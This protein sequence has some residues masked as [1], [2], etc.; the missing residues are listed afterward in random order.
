[1]DIVVANYNSNNVGVFLGYGDGSFANQTTYSTDEEPKSIAVADLNNDSILDIV[2]AN[3][4]SNNLGVFL[5]H[6]D[7]T[8]AKMIRVPLE[9]GSRPFMILVGDFNNDGKLDFAVANNG[10]DSLQILL[11]TC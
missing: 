6:G 9:Y 4:G 5:G 2:V 1:V 10:T 11:Q 7:G 8:F 3:Y